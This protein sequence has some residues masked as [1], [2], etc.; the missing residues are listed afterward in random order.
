[1]EHPDLL[2]R[3]TRHATLATLARLSGNERRMRDIEGTKLFSDF[4]SYAQS[5]KE[6]LF[7]NEQDRELDR[8]DRR[9]WLASKLA[10][11]EVSYEDWVELEQMRRDGTWAVD[12][13]KMNLMD[14]LFESHFA[15]YQN[16]QKRDEIF[17]TN[18]QKLLKANER[19]VTSDD[20]Q[21]TALL[22]AGGFHAHGLCSLLKENGISYALIMPEIKNMPAESHYRAHMRGDVS[23]KNYFEVK[24]GKVNLYNA[25][26]RGTRDRLLGVSRPSP[27]AGL[28]QR[29]TSDEIRDTRD[30][31]LLKNWRDQII[32][33]LAD[34]GRIEKA[35]EYTRFI[36]ELTGEGRDQAVQ[37]RLKQVE[38]FIE[39][40]KRLDAEG[41]FNAANIAK[42]FPTATVPDG[43]TAAGVISLKSEVRA[44]S[45]GLDAFG[46]TEVRLAATAKSEVRSQSAT[47][48]TSKDLPP[49]NLNE[50]QLTSLRIISNES[51]ARQIEAVIDGNTIAMDRI[52]SVGST[53]D[54]YRGGGFVLKIG[55][56]EFAQE[57]GESE[58]RISAAIQQK[59]SQGAVVGGV[60]DIVA[61]GLIPVGGVDGAPAERYFTL[62]M[63]S[64]RAVDFT[65][66]FPG[67]P[68]KADF[69]Q[70]LEAFIQ[71]VLTVQSLFDIGI[72]PGDLK[73]ANL[74]VN[75]AGE[76]MLID[77]GS[78]LSTEELS[79]ESDGFEP[80]TSRTLFEGRSPAYSPKAAERSNLVVRYQ[81]GEFSRK[82]L[83]RTIAVFELYRFLIH[84]VFYDLS[85]EGNAFTYV[86]KEAHIPSRVNALFGENANSALDILGRLKSLATK[87][88]PKGN[89]ALLPDLSKLVN[90]LLALELKGSD[91]VAPLEVQPPTARSEVLSQAVDG[92]G[93]TARSEVR[94]LGVSSP[95]KM[96]TFLTEDEVLRSTNFDARMAAALSIRDFLTRYMPALPSQYIEGFNEIFEDL[97]K[98]ESFIRWFLYRQWTT[99]EPFP[100]PDGLLQ[101]MKSKKIDPEKINE[102]LKALRFYMAISNGYDQP[103]EFKMAE[104]A[105]ETAVVET[106][107][108][109]DA[110]VAQFQQALEG[111][112][113][114][115]R[116][117]GIV[118][119]LAILTHE[120]E[121]I[122]KTVKAYADN[123]K[124]FGHRGVTLHIF[125][126]SQD[127][128]RSLRRTEVMELA[129]TEEFEKA[130]ITLH[131]VG[132]E[133]RDAI[134]EE[135]VQKILELPNNSD[136]REAV[137]Q[138][139]AAALSP[140]GGVGANRNW[141]MLL[142]G[143]NPMAMID[144]DV[145]PAFTMGEE[146]L[147]DAA[148]PVD[149]LSILNRGFSVPQNQYVSFAY[150]GYQDTEALGFLVEYDQRQTSDPVRG[151]PMKVT[152]LPGEM[153]SSNSQGGILGVRGRGAQ[154]ESA[155]S[156]PSNP[157][158]EN[159][160]RTEDFT[161]GHLTNLLLSKTLFDTDQSAVFSPA[162]FVDHNRE[163][164]GRSEGAALIDAIMKELV[165]KYIFTAWYTGVYQEKMAVAGQAPE[166]ENVDAS[167]RRL[168]AFGRVLAESVR[169]RKPPA[170][171]KTYGSEFLNA[172][173]KLRK[174]YQNE[175]GQL[176]TRADFKEGI[177]V[178]FSRLGLRDL[179]ESQEPISEKD[180]RQE[181]ILDLILPELEI[182]A[183]TLEI[184]PLL[185]QTQAATKDGRGLEMISKGVSAEET[186]RSEV[187]AS[188][189]SKDL[190]LDAADE[191]GATAP[192]SFLET[193]LRESQKGLSQVGV[194]E[195]PTRRLRGKPADSALVNASQ[196]A[197]LS[198]TAQLE[199]LVIQPPTFDENTG[200]AQ[201]RVFEIFSRRIEGEAAG[202]LLAWLGE[203]PEFGVFAVS[204]EQLAQNEIELQVPIFKTGMNG[205]LEPVIEDGRPAMQSASVPLGDNVAALL[206]SN[207]V[208]SVD[209]TPQSFE[210]LNFDAAELRVSMGGL[211]DVIVAVD[212]EEKHLLVINQKGLRNNKL[213]L[214]PFGGGIGG[215]TSAGVKFLT[216]KF[217]RGG[218]EVSPVDF[219]AVPAKINKIK[220]IPG[221]AN[222]RITPEEAL[223]L[224]RNDGTLDLR[225][226]LRGDALK[227]RFLKF[228]DWFVKRI[229]RETLPLREL[230]EEVEEQ[231][232]PADVAGAIAGNVA[233][234]AVVRDTRLLRG[235][236]Q[237]RS[238]MRDADQGAAD[239]DP[240]LNQFKEKDDW[241]SRWKIQQKAIGGDEGVFHALVVI[242]ESDE[243]QWETAVDILL[244]IYLDTKHGAMREKSLEVIKG[245]I[246]RLQD[247]ITRLHS[248]KSSITLRKIV[249]KNIPGAL[250]SIFEA[251]EGSGQ[252]QSDALGMLSR[253]LLDKP[254]E[255]IARVI[256]EKLETKYIPLLLETSKASG[257]DEYYDALSALETL[258]Q[259]GRTSALEALYAIASS[260]FEGQGIALRQIESL[261]EGSSPLA[262]AAAELRK[263]VEAAAVERSRQKALQY[264][265]DE[266]NQTRPIEE[267][268]KGPWFTGLL[269][270]ASFVSTFNR[271]MG[272]TLLLENST[273]NAALMLGRRLG[274]DPDFERMRSFLLVGA[275]ELGHHL[276]DSSDFENVALTARDEQ[277]KAVSELIADYV[278]YLVAVRLGWSQTAQRYRASW[279]YHYQDVAKRGGYGEEG[280][281]I[282]RS[283]IEGMF[284]YFHEG[285]Q[286]GGVP[287][288][289]NIRA[290]AAS[291]EIGPPASILRGDEN[292][293]NFSADFLDLRDRLEAV[294]S[295][296]NILP[297][298]VADMAKAGDPQA[299]QILLEV[300]KGDVPGK[301]YVANELLNVRDSLEI[302][303]EVFRVEETM[304]A[305]IEEALRDGFGGSYPALFFIQAM[306][307]KGNREAANELLRAVNAGEEGALKT[308]SF[309]LNQRGTFPAEVAFLTKAGEEALT[310]GVEDQTAR[311]MEGDESAVD[312]LSSL[313]RDGFLPAFE[314]LGSLL[315][316]AGKVQFRVLTDIAELT[317]ASSEV[318]PIARSFLSDHSEDILSTLTPVLEEG[319]PYEARRALEDLAAKNTDYVLDFLKREA[320]QET[321][322]TLAA[323]KVFANV[324]DAYSANPHAV[325]FSEEVLREVMSSKQPWVEAHADSGLI[326]AFERL[327]RKG[328]PNAFALIRAIASS[329]VRG[330]TPQRKTAVMSAVNV[331]VRVGREKLAEGS[332]DAALTEW[333]I[334][335]FNESHLRGKVDLP[336][337]GDDAKQWLVSIYTSE[338]YPA[339]LRMYA[340]GLLPE[341]ELNPSQIIPMIP[342][343]RKVLEEAAPDESL[344]TLDAFSEIDA[345]DNERLK[346][347]L[348]SLW[349]TVLDSFREGT[350]EV[351]D[352]ADHALALAGTQEAPPFAVFKTAI[353]HAAAY[354]KAPSVRRSSLSGFSG[355]GASIIF[356][357]TGQQPSQPEEP[358][359]PEYVA[360][361][362]WSAPEKEQ[363]EIARSEVRSSRELNAASE[364]GGVTRREWIKR[365]A[366][367]GASTAAGAVMDLTVLKP[368][369]EKVYA[370][371]V[372]DLQAKY[373]GVITAANNNDVFEEVDM[374]EALDRALEDIKNAVS[375]PKVFNDVLQRLKKEGAL[376]LDTQKVF[377][378]ES[379]RKSLSSTLD[380]AQAKAIDVYWDALSKAKLRY[381]DLS[382]NK[383][384]QW[385][386]ELSALTIKGL[387]H[388]ALKEVKM[389]IGQEQTAND[390]GAQIVFNHVSLELIANGRIKDYQLKLGMKDN[391]EIGYAYGWPFGAEAFAEKYSSDPALKERLQYFAAQ[392]LTR[393]QQA[394]PKQ[395]FW[396]TLLGLF[397]GVGAAVFLNWADR[398]KEGEESVPGTTSAAKSEV[399]AA[400]VV[401]SVETITRISEA[402]IFADEV[403]LDLKAPGPVGGDLNH[404]E[405]VALAKD[406][407]EGTP[408]DGTKWK[409]GGYKDGMFIRYRGLRISPE[410]LENQLATLM[411]PPT[412]GNARNEIDYT[413]DPKIAISFA[414]RPAA[415]Q[416]P[417]SEN[418][419]SVVFKLNLNAIKPFRRVGTLSMA[420]GL[421]NEEEMSAVKEIF[422]YDKNKRA[423][424]S[425][426]PPTA[427]ESVPGTKSGTGNSRVAKS[428]VRTAAKEP[429]KD[430]STEAFVTDL[431]PARSEV[432]VSAIAAQAQRARMNQIERHK[433][434]IDA[435]TALHQRI[436]R[437]VNSTLKTFDLPVDEFQ[438]VISDSDEVDAS[439][440][441]EDK[442]IVISYGFLK[443]LNDYKILD[444]DTIIFIIGHAI[445]HAA[446]D[447]RK[448]N[449]NDYRPSPLTEEYTADVDYGLAA[450]EA[451]GRSPYAG[452]KLMEAFRVD[453][454]QGKQTWTKKF[455]RETVRPPLHRRQVNIRENIRRLK[456][457]SHLTA[458]RVEIPESEWQ[459]VERS[460]R[461]QFDEGLYSN[462]SLSAI[463]QNIRN[464]VSVHD[465]LKLINLFNI[466]LNYRIVLL[467]LMAFKTMGISG[468]GIKIDFTE[469]TSQGYVEG[470]I[471]DLT[472]KE[473]NRAR[474]KKFI[475][476]E[477]VD[478][479]Q[480]FTQSQ[481][482]SLKNEQTRQIEKMAQSGSI[483][484]PLNEEDLLTAVLAVIISVQNSHVQRASTLAA[485]VAPYAT[486]FA[487]AESSYD[488][489]EAYSKEYFHAVK[490][491]WWDTNHPLDLEVLRQKARELL[492]RTSPGFEALSLNDQNQLIEHLGLPGIQFLNSAPSDAQRDRDYLKHLD[493]DDAG[494]V[495]SFVFSFYSDY[496]NDYLQVQTEEG[497]K[498]LRD[499]DARLVRIDGNDNYFNYIDFLIKGLI[500]KV[501]EQSQE[502]KLS[503]QDL[504]KIYDAFLVCERLAPLYIGNMKPLTYGQDLV[505]EILRTIENF[506]QLIAVLKE[507]P[508]LL[509]QINHKTMNRWI[510]GVQSEDQAKRALEFLLG[511]DN[512]DIRNSG[513]TQLSS[514]MN[515]MLALNVSPHDLKAYLDDLL[516]RNDLEKKWSNEKNGVFAVKEGHPEPFARAYARI[517]K[518]IKDLKERKRLILIY[519]KKYKHSGRDLPVLTDD[520]YRHQD[521]FLA[522]FQTTIEEENMSLREQ[523]DHLVENG[524]PVIRQLLMSFSQ[525]ER[526]EAFNKIR[527]H[528][529]IFLDNGILEEDFNDYL[530]GLGWLWFYETPAEG[531]QNDGALKTVASLVG[532]AKDEYNVSRDL[533]AHQ[534]LS[535]RNRF[536]F[537]GLAEKL[538]LNP[539]DL[540]D[541]DFEI[542]FQLLGYVDKPEHPE[543]DNTD[544]KHVRYETF[545]SGEGNHQANYAA[546]RGSYR[547]LLT[548]HE[549]KLDHAYE[550]KFG[551][552]ILALWLQKH[553][554]ASFE[555]KLAV[556]LKVFPPASLHRNTVILNLIQKELGNALHADP[557]RLDGLLFPGESSILADSPIRDI[558][559]RRIIEAKKEQGLLEAG[560]YEKIKVLVRKYFSE[561]SFV[562]DEVLHQLLQKALIP[563]DDLN[564]LRGDSIHDET[565]GDRKKTIGH[566]IL[567]IMAH[568]IEEFDPADK[569]AFFEWLVGIKRNGGEKPTIVRYLEY[570]FEVNL[571]DASEILGLLSEAERYAFLSTLFIGPSGVLNNTDMQTKFISAVYSQGL[572]NLEFE[573]LPDS[574]KE[575]DILFVI[576]QAVFEE[577]PELKRL[578]LVNGIFK[579]FLKHPG[580]TD[581]SSRNHLIRE[582]L[583]SFGV[584]GV[585]LGQILSRNNLITD[586]ELKKVLETLSDGVDPLDKRYLLNALLF[587]RE[588]GGLEAIKKEVNVIG[589]LLGS[590]SVKQGY[591]SF[592]MD[593]Q[594]NILS[595]R[596]LKFIRPMAHVEV[597]ENMEILER[598]LQRLKPTAE[599]V[600]ELAP[601][602]KALDMI[603]G[604]LLEELKKSIR[605]EMDMHG[606]IESQESIAELL[607]GFTMNGW[608]VEV[609][610]VD[611]QLKGEQ[612]FADAFIY[613]E[614]PKSE[615][616]SRLGEAAYQQIAQVIFAA[617]LKQMLL[618]PK[619][620]A[621]LHPGNIMVNVAEKKIYFMDFGNTSNL[622]SSNQDLFI[623]LFAALDSGNSTAAI[624][625]L[626]TM[627]NAG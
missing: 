254:G 27:V 479:R 293:E 596:A 397:T 281:E 349:F 111:G 403:E 158:R 109:F 289:E 337:V 192:I 301:Y 495:L 346:V 613:G 552:H 416:E 20:P 41:K 97:V 605:R 248:W 395:S 490:T 252:T 419:V 344:R 47:S 550:L 147:M 69:R 343:A 360:V 213:K 308:L 148:L 450:L 11:L 462:F 506:D 583:I 316:Q 239:L 290:P 311:A 273:A 203:H 278:A 530:A 201:Q 465:L 117:E 87:L 234:G 120:R 361:P 14:T 295:F 521:P 260:L 70:R 1:R 59:R 151:T 558:L 539:A 564:E 142:L 368:P 437:I 318:G 33:D 197:G 529:Q 2:D 422:I 592:L 37:K 561:E 466:F 66:R 400:P 627:K 303:E 553:P 567:E 373:P 441:A 329:S 153:R 385:K 608:T 74:L 381:S 154:A 369:A 492:A 512:A 146:P 412:Q 233:V 571:D 486:S 244:H 179:L 406:M 501:S 280:H 390:T 206:P 83:L 597:D 386:R 595:E 129:R 163:S 348:L 208:K 444:E 28:P 123:L 389:F 44:S 269:A 176:K 173:V 415:G 496:N 113:V 178:W 104:T 480:F 575:K 440:L 615:F 362:Y 296:A 67:V 13:L 238:E 26:I 458:P 12:G 442:V 268:R 313:A 139:V 270:E 190:P 9:L 272:Q 546:N 445:G 149:F 375:E 331:L 325:A 482:E 497:L 420:F 262:S 130:G 418:F 603:S 484:Q 515:K 421:Q 258:A 300:A 264:A 611:Q 39:G 205:K 136:S 429:K 3:G 544:P 124:R 90:E 294:D 54:V 155:V 105:S 247:A 24:N 410:V 489:D 593:E 612:F 518:D 591:K 378:F 464:A 138:K 78:F 189:K 119:D 352:E 526:S 351:L 162:S 127:D 38:R 132:I 472:K 310:K 297:R 491:A 425:Y 528:K 274:E 64:P 187:R 585:K 95:Q 426:D 209:L 508:Q 45:I 207:I 266:G 279:A 413:S 590:A 534:E 559:A 96:K 436:K 520:R 554:A 327:A 50:H 572:G 503:Q 471:E 433:G 581:G 99:E 228:V 399:R 333:L 620:H 340:F 188:V 551:D 51:G 131:Y 219:E 475:K 18:L 598:V 82:E 288:A 144:D 61:H 586:V 438:L 388:D 516:S 226:L 460:G 186:A 140:S 387:G 411:K 157:Q 56:I 459:E 542:L 423:F 19:R 610:D 86:S 624:K 185:I 46:R 514:F 58:A 81:K 449:D 485:G 398:G 470:V 10:K 538:N 391:I 194:V 292:R 370:N 347:Y 282:A 6:S 182:L 198:G 152:R 335:K 626:T 447:R 143:D 568:K 356:K 17:Y 396:A 277:G 405:W 527:A 40:L 315:T 108:V 77:L 430:F 259:S 68:Q 15:F 409:E 216:E 577:S 165:G 22:V 371:T 271:I 545:K 225:F 574:E 184:W 49:E 62:M 183:E 243:P 276:V 114:P 382:K 498:S 106:G 414:F 336:P 477:G 393:S 625:I 72:A 600:P 523:F 324:T 383:Q 357:L 246:Q 80:I 73:G 384:D 7:K 432:R 48:L 267:K 314:A 618:N 304:E 30:P 457:W 536:K 363:T 93:Q 172:I 242:A 221:R 36:D 84:D 328:S 319:S 287:G 404:P 341:S 214:S 102:Y 467:E 168:A 365:L 453:K 220:A 619:Y 579:H 573:N 483:I 218:I 307:L 401:S 217:D 166:A 63:E 159:Y 53:A 320:S 455:S 439:Y 366:V 549:E 265:R 541:Q 75:D 517:F 229:E 115:R 570:E 582:M 522:L 417:P 452:A 231:A 431:V 601:L 118:Q 227:E 35:G 537:D 424:V 493:W 8:R 342:V 42:L 589:P 232:L 4:E 345:A 79:A 76:T 563:L 309:V 566:A 334:Q 434:V 408:W 532:R 323:I 261:A 617:I 355:L 103:N 110:A 350:P 609:P 305:L 251:A 525:V 547:G 584:V 133:E 298:H 569:L 92:K 402:N 587:G 60:V 623:Q 235:R 156:V 374:V 25:F 134:Q 367:A 555:E 285:G 256:T 607:D 507:Y 531:E 240:L 250:E 128:E 191:F 372:F 621:D 332:G 562:K 392:I 588:E 135:L 180:I 353:E 210:A 594:G 55:K 428:E 376:H 193:I 255:E 556:I 34:E 71:A 167:Y 580:Q 427:E 161:P 604:K 548:R 257:F 338:A 407:P 224:A 394:K 21:H 200:R 499:D 223:V 286:L 519:Y 245:Q 263:K 195:S 505:T 52:S 23:W 85:S 359:S 174:L 112:G 578:D 175:E 606:E 145:S 565:A 177:A 317:E 302:E 454:N 137:K 283:F 456:Y 511:N 215:L 312:L 284:R 616:K 451:A 181:P 535:V 98:N 509:E 463:S 169:E 614:H 5:V 29:N 543:R 199:G 57:S 321:G 107:S 65:V 196:S 557:L 481:I 339:P 476:D 88:E 504:L 291:E 622:S 230:Q 126:D 171:V 32:R 461:R 212:G 502:K 473:G 478:V 443:F 94:G 533:L 16:A 599:R 253:I 211:V 275:H 322:R 43:A 474:I 91:I 380:T 164:S 540:S 237:S 249:E 560:S 446:I 101:A 602:N 122:V 513:V 150:S 377:G 488:L 31:L 435:S 448:K 330:I 306:I 204:S 358:S 170:S 141:A 160:L 202:A 89:E 468:S 494:Q 510:N 364:A 354:L 469:S 500:R 576:F 379:Y 487:R 121:R 125:D 524:L 241:D 326:A 222:V 116:Y 299:L 236:R 100:V